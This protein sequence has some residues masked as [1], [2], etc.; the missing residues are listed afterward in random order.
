MPLG[1]SGEPPLRAMAYA[2]DVSVFTSGTEEVED[3]V[4]VMKQHAE[5]TDSKINQDMSEVFW[6]GKEGKGFELMMPSHSPG[7]KFKF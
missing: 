3:V 6:M 1:I 7:R 4:S 2:D 5:T